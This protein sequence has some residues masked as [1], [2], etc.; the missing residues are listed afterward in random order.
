M[1]KQMALVLRFVD[2]DGFVQEPFFELVHVFNTAKLTLQNGIFEGRDMM[3]Q[4][5]CEVSG[6]SCKL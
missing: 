4:V 6:M 1:K 5:T 2:K 3:A